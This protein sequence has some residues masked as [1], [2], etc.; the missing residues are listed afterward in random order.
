MPLALGGDEGG[1][2][3]APDIDVD[4]DHDIDPIRF[5][6][7]VPFK[8]PANAFDGD[9]SSFAWAQ[10]ISGCNW[11]G[12]SALT[13]TPAAISLKVLSQVLPPGNDTLATSVAVTYSTDGGNTFTSIYQTT[14]SRSLMT[15]VISLPVN[16]DLTK[17]QVRASYVGQFLA[18]KVQIHEIWIEVTG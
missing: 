18:A 12:W 5:L 17:V 9:Q 14:A 11:F 3:I 15:D 6:G 10:S 16:T 13:R 8:N 1:I 7:R 2:Y 4:F